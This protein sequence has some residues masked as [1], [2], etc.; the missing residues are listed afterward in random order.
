MRPRRARPQRG[1]R[2][3]RRGAERG[4]LERGRVNHPPKIGPYTILGRL[5]QGGMAELFRARHEDGGPVVCLKRILPDFL[6]DED[7]SLVRQFTGEVDIAM[8][9]HHPNIVEVFRRGEDEGPFYTMELIQ[10]P[11]V[12][13]GS[14]VHDS[15]TLLFS[16]GTYVCV[17]CGFAASSVVRGLSLVCS[18]SISAARRSN[19]RRIQQ[20]KLPYWL[21]VAPVRPPPVPQWYLLDP[22]R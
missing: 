14:R 6:D 1:R 17:H 7:G 5:T 16:G 11:V 13:G 3:A 22:I 19:L 21:R 2:S 4:G 8:S 10:G 12:I 18:G 9:L 15:H 20:G